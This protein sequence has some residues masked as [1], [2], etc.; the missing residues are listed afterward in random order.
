MQILCPA[1][2]AEQKDMLTWAVKDHNGPVAVRYPRGGNR[3]YEDSCWPHM[4]Y[5]HRE[6]DDAA[7]ITYGILVEQAVKAAELLAQHGKKIRVVRLLRV[8]PVP[9]AELKR[10]LKGIHNAFVLEETT[11]ASGIGQALAGLLEGIHVTTIDLGDGFVTHG[12][13]SQ[14]YRHCGIDADSVAKKILEVIRHEN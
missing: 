6:G 2:I 12:S 7:I 10:E 13:I 14:L 9:A 3:W 8:S 4:V 11:A 5:T 1:S